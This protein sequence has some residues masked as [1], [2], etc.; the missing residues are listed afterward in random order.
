MKLYKEQ[1]NTIYE[2]QKELDLSINTLYNYARGRTDIDKMQIG[3]L[4]KMA[5]L[6]HKEPISLYYAMKEYIGDEQMDIYNEIMQSLKELDATI[7]TLARAGQEYGRAF[8]T[9]RVELS[10]ELV[11]LKSE[12]YAITLA[13]NIARGKTGIAK[14]KY[15]EISKEAIYKAN[16]EKVNAI[17][18]RIK[19][20]TN[21]YDKEWGNANN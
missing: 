12:G 21:Q 6:E 1:K 19:V 15:E 14:L 11:K 13:E 2:L 18:L 17:K 9:Y 5:K 7:S 4:I 3:T 8:A 16:L 10:K 20:L